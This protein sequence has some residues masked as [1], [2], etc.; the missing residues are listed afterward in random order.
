MKRKGDEYRWCKECRQ[1]L[2]LKT[3]LPLTNEEYYR[4]VVNKY[5]L[6]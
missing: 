3:N 2:N 1:R 6:H 5:A 4:L